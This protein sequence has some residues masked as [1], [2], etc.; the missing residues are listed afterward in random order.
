MEWFFFMKYNFNNKFNEKN[1]LQP[2]TEI[3]E[4]IAYN[5]NLQTTQMQISY[6][7]SCFENY[8]TKNTNQLFN[9]NNWKF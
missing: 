3:H 2:L 6:F 7:I 8:P 5:C 1:L 4:S 9:Y